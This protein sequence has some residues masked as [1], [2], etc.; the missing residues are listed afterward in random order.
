V[1]KL[2][3]KAD[4]IHLPDLLFIQ[5][6]H[7]QFGINRGV[8]NTIDAWFFQ[9]GITNILE[10]RRK[11]HHFLT[12]FQQ[13]NVREKTGKIKIGHGNLTKML[14]EYIGKMESRGHMIS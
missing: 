9:E 11:I 13:K 1:N 8:Y 2:N 10:R 4:I 5:F 12:E 7:D 3:I 14:N 6:C